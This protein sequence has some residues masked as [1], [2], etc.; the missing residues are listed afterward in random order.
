VQTSTKALET[1][2]KKVRQ[3]FD[4]GYPV[5]SVAAFIKDVGPDVDAHLWAWW[6]TL[7]KP[8]AQP[9]DER[10]YRRYYEHVYEELENLWSRA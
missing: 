8:G 1:A 4:Q 7:H 5:D 3:G 9:K 2:Q 6:M 10:A